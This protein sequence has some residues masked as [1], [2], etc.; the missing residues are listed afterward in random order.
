LEG[1]LLH[2]AARAMARK[3]V[4]PDN[5]TAFAENIGEP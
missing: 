3:R 5:G 2:P 1:L 4:K